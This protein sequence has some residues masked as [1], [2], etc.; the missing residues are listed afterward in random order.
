MSSQ[1]KKF[2]VDMDMDD[3]SHPIV[4]CGMWLLIHALLH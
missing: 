2:I 3:K 4:Y 1:D